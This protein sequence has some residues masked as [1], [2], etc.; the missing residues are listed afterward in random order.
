MH[1]NKLLLSDTRKKVH[2]WYLNPQDSKEAPAVNGLIT[3]EHQ[4]ST[5]TPSYLEE[6][7]INSITSVYHSK[8]LKYAMQFHHAALNN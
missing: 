6:P 4:Q 3:S 1:N 2:L 7:M 5:P 8:I